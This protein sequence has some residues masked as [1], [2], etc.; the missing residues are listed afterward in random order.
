MKTDIQIL[1]KTYRF[2]LLEKKLHNK[3][4]Q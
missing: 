3:K 2:I 1:G 4:T